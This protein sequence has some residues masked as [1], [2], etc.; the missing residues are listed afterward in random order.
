MRALLLND[1]I[2]ASIRAAVASAMDHV[3]PLE[4]IKSLGIQ[5]NVKILRLADRK[6]AFVRPL[7][8]YVLIPIGFR[9]ALSFEMQP[10]GLCRHLSISVDTVGHA[11]SQLM[12]EAI[13]AEFGFNRFPLS[14]GRL[15]LEEFEPDHFAVN[16]IELVT[17]PQETST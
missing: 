7:S 5:D 9:A 16:I 6:P 17:K 14:H 8:T 15:W 10:D 4:L 3:I 13:A 11:P 2:R 1:E 12:V